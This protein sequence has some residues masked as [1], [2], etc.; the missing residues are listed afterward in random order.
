[1]NLG[2]A[3]R[4]L[5]DVI[6]PCVGLQSQNCSVEVIFSRKKFK[7]TAI[8]DDDI[9]NELLRKKWLET[10]D[11]PNNKAINQQQY[12]LLDSIFDPNNVHLLEY[13]GKINFIMGRY[14]DALVYLTN[15]LKIE[16]TNTF[17][18]NYRGKTYQM[19]GK[20]KESLVDLYSLLKI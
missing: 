4:D 16:T 18:L 12:N 9:A 17:A 2:I 5:E 6:Y 20:Y 13:Q 11:F 14:E 10:L 3:F 1:M 15:L 7:Y 8:T 19:M